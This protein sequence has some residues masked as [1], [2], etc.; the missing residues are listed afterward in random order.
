MA[1]IYLLI[2]KNTCDVNSVNRIKKKSKKIYF[3][4]YAFL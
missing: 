2:K 3:F 1:Y 4:L